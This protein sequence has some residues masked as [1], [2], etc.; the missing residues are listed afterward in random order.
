MSNDYFYEQMCVICLYSP[1]THEHI[2][3]DYLIKFVMYV[4]KF[5]SVGF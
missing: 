2:F 5:I 1:F 4:H 3:T